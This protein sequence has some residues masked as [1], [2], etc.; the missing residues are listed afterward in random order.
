MNDMTGLMAAVGTAI[1]WAMTSTMFSL[2]GRAVG[3]VVV[4]RVRLLA[5]S[6]LVLVAHWAVLGTLI[7]IQAGVD[8]WIWLSLSGLIGFVLG[9]AFL[10]QAFVWIGPRISMLLMSLAPVIATI[11]S[12]VVLGETLS[13]LELMGILTAVLGVAIVILERN[14]RSM[15]TLEENPYF[16]R[17]LVYGFGAALGQA[18]GLILSKKGLYGD[19][20]ALS[21]NL[22]RLISATAA[23]WLWTLAIRQV[24]PTIASIRQSQ[25]AFKFILGGSITGP[26]LGVWLSLVAV[27]AIEV[28][29][30]STL[31][32]L[33]P[34]F[35]LPLSWWIFKDRFGWKAILGTVMAVGGGAIL[36]IVV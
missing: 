27:Q 28:G 6:L 34:V 25:Q 22:I 10:F 35:L 33:A 31:M 20:S 7:P 21:G 8:R 1:L 12:W 32:G 30:A 2:A 3:S 11:I 19:F 18:L 29:I 17:G 14:G 23:I 13:P 15:E 36:F 24:R 16:R 5:A 4:N 9:D 26:F